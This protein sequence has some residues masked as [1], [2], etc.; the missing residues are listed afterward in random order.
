MSLYLSMAVRISFSASR[1][2]RSLIRLTLVRASGTA[3]L[4]RTSRIVNAT[5][6]STSVIPLALLLLNLLV[7][8]DVILR[9][10]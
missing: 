8:R 10:G 5:I 9:G 7:G 2:C 6:S 4:V 1:S 3:M